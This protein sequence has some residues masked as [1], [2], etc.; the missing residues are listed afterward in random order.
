ML[1]VCEVVE[2]YAQPLLLGTTVLVCALTL[3]LLLHVDIVPV[4]VLLAFA[5]LA[6]LWHHFPHVLARRP[7]RRTATAAP[8][9]P[10][11]SFSFP[12]A[13]LTP[14]PPPAPPAPPAPAA[15]DLA[16]APAEDLAPLCR[17]YRTAGPISA[18]ESLV[19][20]APVAAAQAAPTT[21]RAPHEDL[22]RA[23]LRLRARAAS[24]S[25]AAS[26]ASSFIACGEDA[27]DSATETEAEDAYGTD[28]FAGSGPLCAYQTSVPAAH[29]RY[30]AVAAESVAPDTFAYKEAAAET[31][32]VLGVNP[33]LLPDYRARAAAWL[34]A[35]VV[36]PLGAALRAA[37]QQHPAAPL[38]VLR[39]ADAQLLGAAAAALAVAP[40]VLAARVAA[41]AAQHCLEHGDW[42]GARSGLADARVLAALLC[43]HFDRAIPGSDP[44][45]PVAPAS[46]LLAGSRAAPLAGAFAGSLAG[47]DAAAAAPRRVFSEQ[48]YAAG[49]A[50][51]G[52]TRPRERG[53]V[54]LFERAATPPHYEV[55]FDGRCWAVPPGH[56][57]FLTAL[58]L[59][60]RA[61]DLR[62]DGHLGA[63]SLRSRSCDL[64]TRLNFPRHLLRQF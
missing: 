16:P 44:A 37:Q 47:F 20:A 40:A 5:A 24:P 48:H 6:V 26:F 43:A 56:Q 2:P 55:W 18:T 54:L 21:P 32:A 25:P 49:P 10:V 60:A 58:V 35:A 15:G 42:R 29:A 1:Y 36:A 22:A 41:L 57:N 64:L 12:P 63:L 17:A 30:R 9:Q 7:G 34:H 13:T 8:A 33:A 45:A 11:Y 46:A 14:P 27:A 39:A 51:P 61:V 23:A 28:V 59:F 62:L 31:C 53:A 19:L 52:T 38:A 3:S 50:L 4:L